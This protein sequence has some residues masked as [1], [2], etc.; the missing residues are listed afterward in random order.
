MT[1]TTTG[2][3]ERVLAGDPK[4]FEQLVVDWQIEVWKIVAY[5]LRDQA[6][7]EDLMQQ[8]FL[9][10]YTHLSSFDPD[11]DFG[12][13]LRSIARN[14]VRKELRRRSR[15][16]QRLEHYRAWY[17]R[18]LAETPAAE[19]RAGALR[20]ALDHCREG[21]GPRAREALELRYEQA[22]N[23]PAIASRLQR[24]A[25]AVRQLLVRA[26]QALRR[27]IETRTDHE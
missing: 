6:A 8:V 24:S 1:G 22:L 21:L 13:W 19:S 26:R 18:Q 23:A 9:N 4:A 17:E 25:A 2:I 27:C 14:E 3:I 10:V 20:T 15:Y 11:R 12:A 16:A 5:A 7:S